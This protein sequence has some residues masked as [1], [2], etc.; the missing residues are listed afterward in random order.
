MSLPPGKDAVVACGGET[1]QGK[2]CPHGGVVAGGDENIRSLPADDAVDAGA[3]IE[4]NIDLDKLVCSAGRSNGR[5]QEHDQAGRLA[6][7]V[8]FGVGVVVG[9]GEPAAVVV[10]GGECAPGVGFD[11]AGIYMRAVPIDFADEAGCTGFCAGSVH[12]EGEG[13]AAGRTPDKDIPGGG[14]AGERPACKVY[15]GGGLAHDPADYDGGRAGGDEGDTQ[16]VG[17][18]IFDFDGV[19]VALEESAEGDGIGGRLAEVEGVGT[20]VVVVLVGGWLAGRNIA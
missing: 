16:P 13:G 1:A 11:C 19:G 2:D 9:A 14:D 20:Q 7:A 5:M 4:G 15:I 6:E 10:G 12:L 3:T 17:G 8:G 18:E